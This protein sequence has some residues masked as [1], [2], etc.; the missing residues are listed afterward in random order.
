M[1]T[2]FSRASAAAA[3]VLCAAS[4]AQAVP[5]YYAFAGQVIYTNLPGYP[6]GMDVTYV[7]RVD[8]DATGYE[9]DGSGAIRPQQDVFEGPD[10]FRDYFLADYIGGSAI[11]ADNPAAE[12]HESFHYGMDIMR[13]QD[14]LYSRLLGSNA[15]PGGGDFIDIWKTGRL[16]ADWEVGMGLLGEN[17]VFNG[18][19]ELNGSYSSSLTLVSIGADNPLGVAAVPEPGSRALFALGLIG[20]GLALRRALPRRA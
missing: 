8:R 9:V 1:A 19:G 14:D 13:Y 12:L 4:L 10:Y 16:F 18:P 20:L 5:L 11:P 15:D 17:G 6:L 3:A 2:R 7:F